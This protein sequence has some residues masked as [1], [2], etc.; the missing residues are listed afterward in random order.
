MNSAAP[1]TLRTP[2]LTLRPLEYD[3]CDAIA[4]GVG[5]YDVSRWLAVVPYP[6]SPDDARGFLNR[7]FQQDNSFWAICD[8][9]GLI[10]IISLD[11]ELAYWLARAAW[12][13][14]Y[15]FEAAH[16]VVGCWFSNRD[17]MKLNSGYFDGNDR[18][19]ALLT[20]LGFQLTE[21]VKRF[22]RSFNQDVI[23]NQMTLSRERWEAR[24][25]FTIYTPRLTLRPLED[26]DAEGLRAVAVEEVARNLSTIPVGLTLENAYAFIQEN[27]FQGLPGLRIAIEKEGNYI[28]GLGF[29]DG[30]LNIGYFLHPDHWGQGLMTEALSAFL[31]ALYERFP[32]NKIEAEHFA[33]NPASGAVLQK[34][35]F[36]ATGRDIGTSLARVEPAPVITYAVTRETLKVPA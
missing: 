23:S 27:K 3:D 25:G 35:G 1:P 19:G 36:V 15:G 11:G 21:R 14:G 8:R 20:A 16:A 28:G 29:G 12:G 4:E 31:P 24:Q 34:L 7:V 32:V 5:N 9:S 17:N 6:Y 13:K 30:P 10:G 18:S 2:R 22:A 33:D 26:R